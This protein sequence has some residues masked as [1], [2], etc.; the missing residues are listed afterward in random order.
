MPTFL[1]RSLFQASDLL[2]YNIIHR[3]AE[4][5]RLRNISSHWGHVD[6]PFPFFDYIGYCSAVHF[7]KLFCAGVRI[8]PSSIRGM[9]A[10]LLALSF[11]G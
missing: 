7:F 9:H 5:K 1:L 6:L 3:T 4:R 2:T 8:L 10:G 11:L